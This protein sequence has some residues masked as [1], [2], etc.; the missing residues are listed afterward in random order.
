MKM[1]GNRNFSASPI[2]AIL[3]NKKNESGKL[4]EHSEHISSLELKLHNFLGSPLNKHFL[5]ANYSNNILTLHTDSSIWASKLRYCIPDILEFMQQQCHL[6]TLKT[7]R[8]KVKPAST[9]SVKLPV[10]QLKLSAKSSEF[11]KGI[12]TSMTDYKLR[13]SLLKFTKHSD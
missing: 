8:I 11:I 2:I 13:T 9:E 3:S 4:Y 7:I 1:K 5:L 10:R 6:D 12:A